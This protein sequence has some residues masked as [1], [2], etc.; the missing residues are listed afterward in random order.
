MCHENPLYAPP[1]E[2][3]IM[4][5]TLYSLSRQLQFV[6]W[7]AKVTSE[8]HSSTQPNPEFSEFFIAFEPFLHK[9]VF[10]DVVVVS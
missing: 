4:T 6:I 8:H 3:V 5:A 1:G 2:S 9:F 7:T 10:V